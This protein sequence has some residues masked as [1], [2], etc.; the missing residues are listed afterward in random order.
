[1]SSWVRLT[2]G[3]TY[4]EPVPLKGPKNEIFGSGRFTQM[5]PLWVGDLG[6]R[7]NNPKLVWF[8]PEN[9]QFLFFSAVGYN[10]KDFLTL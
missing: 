10:P 6:T 3:K 5:R 8:R 4:H 1:M 2:G 7:S 9:R